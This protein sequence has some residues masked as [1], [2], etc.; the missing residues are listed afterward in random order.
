MLATYQPS[1]FA[2]AT[3][4]KQFI[5]KIL[6]D[7]FGRQYRVVFA[8]SFVDGEVRGRVISATLIETA[9][10]LKGDSI[11]KAAFCL[12]SASSDILSPF[13]LLHN[14]NAP[15]SRTWIV[16]RRAVGEDDSRFFFHFINI[17]HRRPSASIPACLGTS[18][19]LRTR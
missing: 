17:A 16:A 19:F 13:S 1:C 9:P 3:Q 15:P 14:D 18:I 5:E 7:S 6:T 12:P 2:E 4:D 10:Q 11:N 8:V